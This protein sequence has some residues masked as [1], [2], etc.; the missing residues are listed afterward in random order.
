MISSIICLGTDWYQPTKSSTSQVVD[1]FYRRGMKIL[2]INPVPVRF[3]SAKR[4]DFWNRVQSKAR[5]H[6]R[7]LA[8]PK[9][10][11]YVY[12]PIFFPGFS[13][14]AMRFNRLVITAQVMA[15]SQ[16]LRMT[17]PLIFY[18]TYT[19]W[20]ALPLL[21]RAPSVFHF[22]DKLSAFR[23]TSTN[24]KKRQM[25]DTM[26]TELIQAA[27]L[28]TCSSQSIY[29]HALRKASDQTKKVVYLPHG[30]NASQFRAILEGNVNMPDDLKNIC[31]PIAGYF[32]S[33]TEANDKA[34]FAY[35]AKHC[36]DWSFVFIGKVAGDYTELASCK[37]VFFLGQKAYE[38]IPV[39]GKFFDV[40]FMGWLPHEWI[41]NCSPIKALEYLALGKPV[42]C[43]SYITELEKYASLVRVTSTPEEF[44]TALREAYTQNTAELVQR[45]LESVRQYSWDAHVDTILQ[46]LNSQRDDP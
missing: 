4:A 46:V 29:E 8:T 6:A 40:C 13:E 2:W 25:L 27:S 42:I 11:I 38:E 24:P 5:T 28:I 44:V 41:T 37:N 23:E 31:K 32:G 18:S 17:S 12:S 9:K 43:S 3:P 35:A 22:A 10:G 39:Y 19:A 14:T 16:I 45:R 21:K 20:Y 33:L 7:F 30:V 15:L 26:E 36:P 1:G 34:T